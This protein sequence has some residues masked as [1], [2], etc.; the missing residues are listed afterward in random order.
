MEEKNN[1]CLTKH[2]MSMLNES[3][4]ELKDVLVDVALFDEL[5]VSN[6]KNINV[7]ANA[8]RN[9]ESVLGLY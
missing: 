7:I 5:D 3:A 8:I 9:I 6:Q 1:K 4:N 2:E